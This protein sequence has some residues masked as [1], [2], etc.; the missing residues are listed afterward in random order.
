MNTLSS[1]VTNTVLQNL[2]TKELVLVSSVSHELNSV[3]K[4]HALSKIVNPLESLASQDNNLNIRD[5][6]CH[7]K[8]EIES[9]YTTCRKCQVVYDSNLSKI[10]GYNCECCDTQMCLDCCDEHNF[11]VYFCEKCWKMSCTECNSFRFD[12]DGLCY[13]CDNANASEN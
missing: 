5:T 7:D 2:T 1:I 8:K 6:G 12:R 10:T 3:V 4:K 13:D 9:E 11:M